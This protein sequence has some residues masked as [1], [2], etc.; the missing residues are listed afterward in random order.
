MLV[1]LLSVLGQVLNENLLLDV[2]LHVE[3][4]LL[5]RAV[6][7]GCILCHLVVMAESNLEMEMKMKVVKVKFHILL[8][9]LNLFQLLVFF[10]VVFVVL[11]VVNKLRWM[12]LDLVVRFHFP[13]LKKE[14]SPNFFFFFPKISLKSTRS[15]LRRIIQWEFRRVCNQPFPITSWLIQQQRTHDIQKAKEK[16]GKKGNPSEH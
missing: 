4:K 15:S 13:F 2:Q 1:V 3:E 14:L 9:F 6:V 12:A 10:E 11:H 8:M 16:K 5:L 7:Y